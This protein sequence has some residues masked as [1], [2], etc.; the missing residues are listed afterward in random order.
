MFHASW[1]PLAFHIGRV[2]PI[3]F[4]KTSS[5]NGWFHP[6]KLHRRSSPRR[7]VP[8]TWRIF[9]V[10][11]ILDFSEEFGENQIRSSWINISHLT[12]GA[13]LTWSSKKQD[14]TLTSLEKSPKYMMCIYIYI[15]YINIHTSNIRYN[16]YVARQFQAR[17]LN[18]Q[19]F[20]VFT[21]HFWVDTGALTKH[22]LSPSFTLKTSR[23]NLLERSSFRGKKMVPPW[24]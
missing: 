3:F 22:G 20:V 5:R 7:M 12:G 11:K 8:A 4:C 18:M 21:R 10:K 15:Y 6:V 2:V 16:T 19:F 9:L 17:F 24:N 23:E 1:C 13:L 14:F